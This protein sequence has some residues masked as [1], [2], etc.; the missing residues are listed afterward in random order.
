MPIIDVLHHPSS[1]T[2]IISL[3]HHPSLALFVHGPTS[4]SFV[5]SPSSST[6]VVDPVLFF[7][8][9]FLY[10][11]SLLLHHPSS[12]SF[13]IHHPSS[14]VNLLGPPSI[15]HHHA[16]S[17]IIHSQ[18]H[19]YLPL[20]FYPRRMAIS[21]SCTCTNLLLQSCHCPPF[22]LCTQLARIAR[23]CTVHCFQFLPSPAWQ[24]FGT[25]TSHLLPDNPSEPQD[26]QP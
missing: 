11:A 20:H 22:A 9:V 1:S 6:F 14:I 19:L 5:H 21:N 16:S 24:S 18:S 2:F 10:H 12:S 15:V 8:S 13:F 25:T 26:P 4:T 23:Y 7:S 3:P 17:S